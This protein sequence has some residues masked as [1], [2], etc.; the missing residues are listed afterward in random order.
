MSTEATRDQLQCADGI[1]TATLSAWRDEQLTPGTQSSLRAHIAD[2]VACQRRLTQ[3]DLT[4]QMLLAQD[5]LEPG[6]R[7]L[8]GVRERAARLAQQPAWRRRLDGLAP[9]AP[10]I[11]LSGWRRGHDSDAETS[12]GADGDTADARRHTTRDPR[13]GARRR[14]WSGLGAVAAV[15][16]VLLLF[17]YVFHTLSLVGAGQGHGRPTPTGVAHA[18]TT[19]PVATPSITPTGIPT[20]VPPSVTQSPTIGAQAAWGGTGVVATV[21]TDIDSTHVFETQSV[22]ADG[23]RLLGYELTLNADGSASA[24][25]KAQLGVFT[26]SARQFTP[27][28]VADDSYFPG[29]CCNDDGRFLVAVDNPTPQATC[30]V[31][32]LRIWSYD[33]A[34]GAL[35]KVATGDDF[36]G[37]GILSDFASGGY[38]AVGYTGHMVF[39]NL[40]TGAIIHIPAT[41]SNTD[42]RLVAFTWPTVV[43]SEQAANGPFTYHVRDLTTGRDMVLPQFTGFVTGEA[44]SFDGG[45][46]VGDTLYFAEG[47]VQSGAPLGLYDLHHLFD[48]Y[49]NIPGSIAGIPSTEGLIAANDRVMVFPEGVWDMNQGRFVYGPVRNTGNGARIGRD[50][51]IGLNGQYLC[52]IYPTSAITSAITTYAHERVVVYDTSHLPVQ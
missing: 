51:A 44:N 23:K 39:I 32:N 47:N 14:T 33:Q 3:F 16:A 7:I 18:A 24:T 40:A 15:A 22:S 20:I 5:E 36:G 6:D 35:R 13:R 52:Y 2:C 9:L 19:P 42:Y 49:T 43:Y 41:A 26:I 28:G 11:W 45:Q 46:I 30:Y 34:T 29:S 48:T 12:A 10:P 17:V 31:C 25:A 21:N 27:I 8:S 38:E 4:A 1:D 50:Y 37:A